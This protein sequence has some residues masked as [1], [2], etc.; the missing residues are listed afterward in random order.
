[1]EQRLRIQEERVRSVL[2]TSGDEGGWACPSHRARFQHCYS[3]C[4][5]A[6][7]LLEARAVSQ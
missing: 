6:H 5:P 2:L 1:M 7:D 3:R 4:D